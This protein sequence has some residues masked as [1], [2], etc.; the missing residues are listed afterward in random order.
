SLRGPRMTPRRARNDMI[1]AT[2]AVEQME[3]ADANDAIDPIESA[4]PTEP[5]DSTEPRE[6]IESREFSDQSDH[7][8]PS[9]GGSSSIRAVSRADAF[10][11]AG[12]RRVSGGPRATSSRA[13]ARP[14]GRT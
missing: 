5:I 8:E 9:D 13:W 3:K 10:Q 14:E 1:D 6:P 4:E 11:S 12:R 7:F 2:E